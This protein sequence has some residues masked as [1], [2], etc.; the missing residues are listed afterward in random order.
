VNRDLRWALG[1]VGPYR[2][3]LGAVLALNLAST[4]LALVL[5]YLTKDLVDRAFL[6]RDAGR[7]QT[8]VAWFAA[9]TLASYALNVAS[10]LLY[11]RASAAILFD[12]RL[13][14]FRHLQ[15]LSP[16]FYSRVRLGEIVARLNNDIGEIQ[17]ISAETLLAWAGNVVFLAGAVAM[18]VWLDVRLF[19]AGAALFP[20]SLWVLARYRGRLADRVAVVRDASAGVGSF[21]IESL[22]GMRLVVSSGAEEREASRF[23]ERNAAFVDGVMRMQRTTYVS[24]G[25]PGL[26]LSAGTAIIFLY[27]GS[28]VI[29]G[30][31]TLGTF[32]AFMAYQ[33]RLLSP[34]QALMGLYTALATMRVSLARVRE[35]L[36]EPVEVE[37]P[38]RPVRLSRVV[39]NLTVD[40]VAVAFGRGAPV[41]DGVSFAAGAGERLAIVGRSGAGK[42]TIADLLL[43]LMDP[44]RGRVC[45]D[46]HDLR[47]L[48]LADLRRRVALVDQQPFLFHATI[49]ENIRYA[50]PD[51][52]DAEVREAAR[53]AGIDEFVQSLPAGYDTVAGE[54]GA[55]LSA[56]ERQRVAIARAFLADPAVLILDEATSALDPAAE[57]HVVS[58]YES[59]MRGRTTIIITHRLA[60]AMT[61]DRVIALDEAR[62]VQEG[63]PAELLRVRGPFAELFGAGGDPGAGDPGPQA[64][65][66][67]QRVADPRPVSI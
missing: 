28:R 39:G 21:L 62:V 55:A 13:S 37:E 36:D 61:A 15:R 14:L 32:A 7:L 49:A 65:S 54:R 1:F 30:S 52:S 58:G 11:T 41:L 31:L 63:V 26:I 9:V 38:L 60:L 46:G 66:P 47:T 42:S 44:D 2:G 12:M 34:V 6:A 8:L 33:M 57:R 51:A 19:L 3:A 10:G 45:L 16:R 27:G 5:P 43:R 50:R 24:G 53:R 20:V 56:G 59:L 22:Q 4:V 23:R 17:R 29:A 48:S 64:P 25:V 40:D 35:I 67:E 18:L